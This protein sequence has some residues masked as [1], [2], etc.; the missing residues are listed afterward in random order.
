[1]PYVGNDDAIIIEFDQGLDGD[2][3][4]KVGLPF[5]YKSVK[6][7]GLNNS[8]NNANYGVS[9]NAFDGS[10]ST[11]W[12][13]SATLP[14]WIAFDSNAESKLVNKLRVYVT[15]TYCPRAFQFQGSNDNIA[16]SDIATGEFPNVTQWNEYTFTPVSYKYFR[17][18]VTSRW[19]S[20]TY[21]YEIE[22]YEAV[23]LG[24]ERAFTVTAQE[25]SPLGI[26]EY[27]T[28][29]YPV[30]S[31]DRRK[32]DFFINNTNWNEG[33]LDNVVINSN[34]LELVYNTTEYAL[35]GSYISSPLDLSLNGSIKSAIL[36]LTGTNL[37]GISAEYALTTSS[38][39]TGENLGT[40]NGSTKDFYLDFFPADTSNIKFYF[41]GVETAFVG[42]INKKHISFTNA[43]TN[44]AVITVDYSGI[45]E[46]LST[47]FISLTVDAEILSQPIN[48]K[49]TKK[50]FWT[51]LIFNRIDAQTT[52]SLSGV[53]ISTSSSNQLQL[54][55]NPLGNRFNNVDKALF[56]ENMKNY[57]SQGTLTNVIT[58]SN[59]LLL[60]GTYD[61]TTLTNHISGIK[62]LYG[63]TI[64]VGTVYDLVDGSTSTVYRPTVT[65]PQWIVFDLLEPKIVSRFR[66]YS[67]ASGRVNS[68]ILQASDDAT[69]WVDIVNSTMP[70]ATQWNQFDFDYKIY[71]YWRVYLVS[72]YTANTYYCYEAE[73]LGGV[74]TNV[75][76][77]GSWIFKL[78]VS[79]LIKVI[80]A[81]MQYLGS[82]LASDKISLSTAI[83]GSNETVPTVWSNGISSINVNDNLDRKYLWLKVELTK[84][85]GS[86]Q[87]LN[88]VIITIYSTNI[89]VQY[90][91]SL[92][93]LTGQNNM[94]VTNFKEGCVINNLVKTPVGFNNENIGLSINQYTVS[95]IAVNHIVVGTYLPTGHYGTVT[96]ARIW[97]DHIKPDE[98]INFSIGN[99]TISRIHINDIN[100]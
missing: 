97:G 34:N 33:T 67:G 1:M 17:I 83:S 32:L 72:G 44:N 80:S 69:N 39:I 74:L 40:G 95:H 48:N 25:K 85:G 94:I 77:S 12:G 93:N 37:T 59:K 98:K 96:T 50:Y 70:N 82:S 54:N 51:K 5:G 23:E 79:N 16:W 26:G 3:T 86:L 46:P 47:D 56:L 53:N 60:Q 99:F 42:T 4:G 84:D 71:R 28:K 78:P 22:L 18:Y 58:T 21:I 13:T 15:T 91:Q 29:E 6:L 66:W 75:A 89:D 62:N 100:P 20:R 88:D 27:A 68:F 35:T 61:T 36:S 87:L 65:S 9:S 73:L 90:T 43:P 49:V 92:G 2:V 81:N 52:P 64:N 38:N 41:D 31:V 11:Y 45:S 8:A 19:S 57:W 55:F 76:D 7:T 10:E 30:E 24:N 63:S 14:N